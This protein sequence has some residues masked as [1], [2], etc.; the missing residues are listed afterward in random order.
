MPIERARLDD[1]PPPKKT[2]FKYARRSART[3]ID[4]ETI[5]FI[6]TKIVKGV[7]LRDIANSMCISP[8]TLNE[9]R[10]RGEIFI[11]LNSNPEWEIF[12]YFVWGMRAAAGDYAEKISNRIHTRKDWWRYLKIAE[13]RMPESYAADPQGGSDE[14]YDPDESFL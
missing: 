11:S 6:C 3:R 10:R 14:L 8:A 1:D 4:D 13:R 7:P 12:G 2:A 9:W 5:E